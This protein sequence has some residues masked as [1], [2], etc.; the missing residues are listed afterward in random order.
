MAGGSYRRVV[1]F[2]GD[3]TTA[4]TC[5]CGF[6]FMTIVAAIVAVWLIGG[7]I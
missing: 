2:S 3:V 1:G 6:A 5:G 7:G 4:D